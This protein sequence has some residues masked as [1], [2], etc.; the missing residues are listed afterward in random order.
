MAWLVASCMIVPLLVADD[1]LQRV[2]S[3][4]ASHSTHLS[5]PFTLDND[6]LKTNPLPD[7]E[8]RNP[9]I[10]ILGN[11]TPSFSPR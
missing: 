8:T 4:S 6:T 3:S 11:A 2:A 1:S 7:V 9:G 5:S 10:A